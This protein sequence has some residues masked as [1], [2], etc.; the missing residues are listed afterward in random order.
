M[1][2]TGV[3][4][5]LKLVW[6]SYRI[7]FVRAGRDKRARAALV[8]T[9]LLLLS[10]IGYVFYL[11]YTAVVGGPWT[12]AFYAFIIGTGIIAAVAMRRWYRNQNKILNQSITGQASLS[13]PGAFKAPQS[14]RSY[15]EE[16][17]LIVASLLARGASE[18]QLH[19]TN[20]SNDIGEVLTRQALNGFLRGHGLWE[21]LEPA[22][23]DLASAADGRWTSEQEGRVIAW[24]EQLRLLRWVLGVDPEIVPLWHNPTVDFKLGWELLQQAAALADRRSEVGPWDIR[25]QRDLATAYATRA[26]AE[27]KVRGVVPAC[28]ELDRWANNLRASCLGDS[29]DFLAGVRTIAEVREDALRL[30]AFLAAAR[31]QYA[32]YLVDQLNAT[33]PIAFSSWRAEAPI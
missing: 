18:V 33:E 15:L 2:P 29:V 3:P 32:G 28:P 26:I 10:V 1:V 30:L 14:V 16:R 7:V 4:K 6:N 27:L 21:R 25:M 17:A 24:C 31:G 8:K 19:S 13:F 9:T 20:Q 12:A 11:S 23:V 22:E 5:R